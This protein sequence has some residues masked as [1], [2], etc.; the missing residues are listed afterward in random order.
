MDIIKLSKNFTLSRKSMKATLAAFKT[1]KIITD[2]T[3]EFFQAADPTSST[4]HFTSAPM[5]SL[6][7]VP[8]TGGS[9]FAASRMS[10]SAKVL[11][12]AK[13]LPIPKETPKEPITHS[14]LAESSLKEGTGT[15][16]LD[17]PPIQAVGV[18]MIEGEATKR[19]R[20]SEPAIEGRT[21]VIPG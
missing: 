19:A 11:A 7:L 6:V 1:K 17:I 8:V 12:P 13:T 14:E 5:P 18:I 3:R 4:H 21:T 2:V 10:I 15:A 9:C 16:P 20:T